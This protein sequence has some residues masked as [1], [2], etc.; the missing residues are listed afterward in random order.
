ML[1]RLFR[2]LRMILYCALIVV[3]FILREYAV[4]E[5]ISNTEKAPE[6]IVVFPLFAEEI[7]YELVEEERV[8]YVGH[9]YIEA[10]ESYWPS[11]AVSKNSS[12]RNWQNTG[13]EQILSLDPDLLIIDLSI[14]ED[15]KTIYP[16]LSTARVPVLFVSAPESSEDIVHLIYDLG[17]MLQEQ[18]KANILIR[19]LE[20]SLKH[21]NLFTRFICCEER[22]TVVLYGEY[23]E[24]FDLVANIS[25]VN[26]Y[27]CTD[28]QSIDAQV[29]F[30]MDKAPDLIIVLPYCTDD[31]LLF[32]IGEKYSDRE[33]LRIKMLFEDYNIAAIRD[34]NIVAL[35]FHGS[36]YIVNS[37]VNLIEIAYPNLLK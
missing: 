24:F 22:K 14:Q 4:S 33:I 27:Y 2:K 17:K 19:K 18:E 5:N 32:S 34:D 8:I 13:E 31:G 28:D 23:N 3:L 6:R 35:D 36:Q 25:M 30:L 11:M 15:Y 21:I 20:T 29:A 1:I 16:L 26:S 37:V 10:G 7:I 12:G 9:P